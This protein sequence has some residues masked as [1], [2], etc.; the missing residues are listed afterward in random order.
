MTRNAYGWLYDRIYSYK[1]YRAE[2][3]AV[4]ALIQRVNPGAKSLLEVACGTGKHLEHLKAHYQAVGLDLETEQLEEA[5]R[6][7]PEVPFYQGDMRTFDLGRTFDAVTCLF[8]AIGYAGGVEG[9]EAAV[10]TMARHLNPGGVLLLEPWLLPEVWQ[11]NRPHALFV[12]EPDLKVARM[13]VSR[14]EGRESVLEFHYLIATPQGVESFTEELR[15]FL[16][17]QEEYLEAFRRA[18]LEVEHDPQGLTGRGLY[19][20]KKA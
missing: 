14:Q 20:G 16:F 3:G 19:V 18:G 6:R 5:R 2:A 12:D 15:L 13:N 17:T 11:N 9:L 8:S 7:N 4:H 10:C 1:D